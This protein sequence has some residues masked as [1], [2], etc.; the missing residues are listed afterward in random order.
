[1]KNY[2]IEQK[3]K[4]MSD[5]QHQ[6]EISSFEIFI[7]QLSN[8]EIKKLTAQRVNSDYVK[9]KSLKAFSVMISASGYIILIAGVLISFIYFRDSRT[10]YGIITVVSALLFSMLLLALSNLIQ[11]F[12]DIEKNTRK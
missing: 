8:E 4:K 1:M 11:V 2:W 7:H 5:E 9:Y 6:G 12:V 10:L 3:S